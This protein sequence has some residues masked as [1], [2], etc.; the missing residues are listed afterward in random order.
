MRAPQRRAGEGAIS[1]PSREFHYGNV[2]TIK[3]TS[4]F[5][6]W[7]PSSSVCSMSPVRDGPVTRLIVS[8][9]DRGG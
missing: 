8:L 3:I 2:G 1:A 9:R 5:G 7:A 4:S 6:P